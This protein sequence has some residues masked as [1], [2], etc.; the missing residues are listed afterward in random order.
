MKGMFDR[1]SPPEDITSRQDQQSYLDT[2]R[3]RI[4][5]AN[6][7]VPA[8]QKPVPLEAGQFILIPIDRTGKKTTT[9]L[10]NEGPFR[11]NKVIDDT[12]YYEHPNFQ[13]EL[14]VHCSKAS[15]YY[16]KEGEI[17]AQTYLD[18][19]GA[20][21]FIVEEILDHSPHTTKVRAS[22]LRLL[23]KYANYEAEWYHFD[24]DLAKTV[25]SLRT[26]YRIPP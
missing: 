9:V 17:P 21:K 11:V 16:P 8:T 24:S 1:L 25:S 26:L 18:S 14:R 19:I 20:N 6:R 10:R 15:R 7:R 3:A 2:A 12:F 22:N 23:V 5:E 13:R 4:L